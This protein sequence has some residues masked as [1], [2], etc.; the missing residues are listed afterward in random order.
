[1]EKRGPS[2]TTV[3]LQEEQDADAAAKSAVSGP[4]GAIEAY[5]SAASD[6]VKGNISVRSPFKGLGS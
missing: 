3:L 5:L 1:M 6:L 4:H 2:E